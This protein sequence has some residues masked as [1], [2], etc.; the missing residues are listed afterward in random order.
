MT[1]STSARSGQRSMLERN[2]NNSP[3]PIPGVF[4]AHVRCARRT[5]LDLCIHL[6]LPLV[7]YAIAIPSCSCDEL[8]CPKAV[9]FEIPV[10]VLDND[11][12]HQL[13]LETEDG[14]SIFLVK[15]TD[16]ESAVYVGVPGQAS[17]TG[18]WH[19]E[20]SAG[21]VTAYTWERHNCVGVRLIKDG[22]VLQDYAIAFEF[23]D[24]YPNGS[25]CE[26]SCPVM[27]SQKKVESCQ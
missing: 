26:P 17:E 24:E 12:L 5:C 15:V 25:S 22:N 8:A 7:L 21:T 6:V 27:R 10:A 14:M 23:D 19:V 1:S 18:G 2:S 9:R 16:S 3:S 13:H 11:A 20:A 4:L